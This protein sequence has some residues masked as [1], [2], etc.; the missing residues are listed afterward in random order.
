MQTDFAQAALDG[1][2]ATLGAK[3]CIYQ[4]PAGTAVTGL[5]LMLARA[6]IRTGFERE[7]IEANAIQIKVR[8]SEL[9]PAKG[10]EFTI[11]EETFEIVADPERTDRLRLEWTCQVVE[12]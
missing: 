12:A 7:V 1:A 8:A 2:Y 4:P 3:D 10:G 5:T 6:E 11:G 9:T